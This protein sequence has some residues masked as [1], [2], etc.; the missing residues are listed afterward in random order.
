[1]VRPDITPAVS[2][3]RGPAGTTVGVSCP[4]GDCW[5]EAV[6]A[7]PAATAVSATTNGGNMTV[8]GITAPVTVSTGG[9]NVTATAVT[10]GIDLSTEGGGVEG[11]AIATPDITVTSGGGNVDLMLTTVPKDL[12]VNS[13][14]GNVTIELPAGSARY[15]LQLDGGCGRD[16]GNQSAVPSAAGTASATWCQWVSSSV[17]NSASSPNVI[18]VSS[19]G[20]QITIS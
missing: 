8:S 13:G 18:V 16:P 2:T 10:G 7:V 4:F 5:T 12:Q 3:T 19:D 15:D 1:M 17:P 6:A 20:G 14:G 9:G 11:T